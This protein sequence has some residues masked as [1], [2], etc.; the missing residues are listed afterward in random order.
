MVWKQIKW[1]TRKESP[2]NSIIHRHPK[3]QE[4]F[5][6]MIAPDEVQNKNRLPHFIYDEVADN[7]TTD[8]TAEEIKIVPTNF[9]KKKVTG[10]TE[11]NLL[12]NREKFAFDK[13]YTILAKA[14]TH[15]LKQNAIPN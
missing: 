9:A 10:H 8:I 14:Y 4:D 5:L 6:N 3:L 13:Y 2:Q 1:F 11:W 15:I 7:L 12:R